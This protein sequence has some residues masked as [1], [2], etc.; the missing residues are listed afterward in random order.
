MNVRHLTVLIASAV[1]AL[2]A[3]A[4]PAGVAAGTAS[5]SYTYFQNGTPA[6]ITV[7]YAAAP[8]EA[9]DA[10]VRLVRSPAGVDVLVRDAAPVTAGPG[11][12]SLTG[13]EA[14][15]SITSEP[16]NGISTSVKLGDGGDRLRL[17]LVGTDLGHAYLEGGSGGDEIVVGPRTG[18]GVTLT[19][20]TGSD[21][22]DA[23]P[24]GGA[25]SYV[26]HTL[27]VRVD[28]DGVDDDGSRGEADRLRNIQIVLGGSGNDVLV[29]DGGA[30][31]LFGRQGAD[32]VH[33]GG[34]NDSLG[35]EWGNDVLTGGTGDDVASGGDGRDRVSGGSGVD[36]I[37]GDA[38]ADDLYARDR[39]AD[40][41]SG[42]NGVDR[43]QIDRGLDVVRGVERRR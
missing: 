5:L 41:V 36:R 16:P 27:P 24:A 6:G 35:G 17:E 7:R 19:G 43:A 12:T 42:G 40:R 21:L 31:A 2:G 20:G 38:G 26:D 22:L 25:A 30:N 32:T 14:V 1:A 39:S 11:F 18:G 8:G 13:D 10:S 23:G 29:G 37:F 33:G 4:L 3:L 15:A 34:G 28:L 9:N